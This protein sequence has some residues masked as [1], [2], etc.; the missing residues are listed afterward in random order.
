MFISVRYTLNLYVFTA[1]CDPLWL[2]RLEALLTDVI[3]SRS[4][5]RFS[6]TSTSSATANHRRAIVLT[7]RHGTRHHT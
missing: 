4:I 5:Q 2:V 3:S 7:H 1:E 6:T